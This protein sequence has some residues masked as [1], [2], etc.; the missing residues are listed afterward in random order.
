MPP[1]RSVQTALNST[2]TNEYLNRIIDRINHDCPYNLANGI[3]ATSLKEG[4][5]TV[6]VELRPEHMNIWGLPH[7]GLIFAVADV[8]SGIAA[9][10]LREGA[11][12]VTAGSSLNFLSANPEAKR[13]R[14]EGRVIRAGRTLNVVQADVYDE[15]GTHLATGQFTM[16]NVQQ[17]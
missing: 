12:I 14:A 4:L 8:A 11:H 17:K 16:Y 10:S 1:Q 5:S 13:L 15:T 9:H 3:T 6:E 2:M 7:G